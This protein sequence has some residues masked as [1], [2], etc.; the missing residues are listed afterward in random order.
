MKKRIIFLL[1]IIGCF[2]ISCTGC[3]ASQYVGR[4]V[5]P[6]RRIPADAVLLDDKG[7]GWIV[8]E[9]DGIKF[10]YHRAGQSYSAESLTRID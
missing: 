1:L 4:I 9:L 3:P 2:F 8:F 10:L 7:N 5:N 6:D